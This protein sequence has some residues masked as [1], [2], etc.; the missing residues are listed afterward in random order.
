MLAA[1]P[2]GGAFFGRDHATRI[3]SSIDRTERITVTQ[4]QKTVVGH[5]RGFSSTD[6]GIFVL[7]DPRSGDTYRGSLENELLAHAFERVVAVGGDRIWYEVVLAERTTT[8]LGQDPKRTYELLSFLEVPP[9]PGP[10]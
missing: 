6:R 8:R 7:L 10:L 9:P 2:S 4:N 1:W 5:F 3:R